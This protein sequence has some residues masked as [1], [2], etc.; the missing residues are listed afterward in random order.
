MPRGALTGTRLRERRALAGLRQA[1]VARAAGISAAYLNLIEHNRRR[2]G[3]ALL[4]RLAEALGVDA[5]ILAE[6]AESALV[7]TLREAAAGVEPAPGAAQPETDRIEDF[8]PAAT[9][10]VASDYATYELL[11]NVVLFLEGG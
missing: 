10:L 8:V 7:E 9:A 3:A 5:E 2:V 1:E 11:A 4:A 6:G